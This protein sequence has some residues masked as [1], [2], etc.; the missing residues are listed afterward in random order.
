M[1]DAQPGGAALDPLRDPGDGLLRAGDHHGARAVDG[2]DREVVAV[3]EQRA[4]G[5][6]GGLDGQHGPAGR[7]LAHQSGAGADQDGGV[8]QGEHAGDMGG[9]DLADGVPGDV[10]GAQPERLQQ[11]VEGDLD[12][13]QR[14]LGVLGALQGLPFVLPPH[15]LAQRAFQHRV[16]LGGDGAE[17]GGEDGER[18]VQLPAHAGALAALAGEEKGG[19][20]ARRGLVAGDQ[21]AG[22]PLPGG[23]GGQRPQG[24]VA[25]LGEDDGASL[26]GGAGGGQRVA[27]VGEVGVPLGEVGVERGRLGAQR[28]AGPGGDDQWGQRQCGAREF[29]LGLLRGLLGG[30][31]LQDDVGVGAGDAERGDA[32]AARP[33]AR[34]PGAGLGQQL[35]GAG[36]PVDVRGGRVDMQ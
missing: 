31:L 4:H 25:V 22:L 28:V 23:E 36:R 12:G 1:R 16:E 10:V 35:D 9:G 34:L 18:L 20:A 26:Q 33:V 2:G 14:R 6:L 11:P 7:E 17:R 15:H 13:E 27:G 32:G 3:A 5:V 30:R 8:L 19:L 24:V 29:G 21:A